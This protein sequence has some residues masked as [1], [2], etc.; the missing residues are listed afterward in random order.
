LKGNFGNVKIVGPPQVGL[1]YIVRKAR[2]Q[3]EAFKNT[4]SGQRP[5]NASG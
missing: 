5:G 4:A 2:E 1:V 3:R